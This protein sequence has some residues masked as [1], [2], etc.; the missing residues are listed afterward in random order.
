MG[1]VKSRPQPL[2]LE[3]VISAPE[4]VKKKWVVNDGEYKFDPT[5]NTAADISEPGML[6]EEIIGIA[7][8]ADG[9]SGVFF[10]VVQSGVYVLKAAANAAQE[11]FSHMVA[12]KL[13]IAV[14]RSK[15]LQFGSEGMNTLT[16]TILSATTAP[17]ATGYAIRN[18][19][20]FPVVML[21]E[22]VV[23]NTLPNTPL[24]QVRE[25]SFLK[26]LGSLVALDSLINNS[27]RVPLIWDNPGNAKNIMTTKRAVVGIDQPTVTLAENSPECQKYMKRLEELL[28]KVAEDISQGSSSSMQ[29]VATF[30]GSSINSCLDDA[31]TNHILAGFHTTMTRIAAISTAD[32]QSCKDAVTKMVD[33]EEMPVG[34]AWSSSLGGIDIAFLAAAA[35]VAKNVLST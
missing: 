9:S 8:S 28:C 10:I 12:D 6:A 30:V 19:L 33:V 13:G 14:S 18:L 27:D 26:Q 20:D 4:P 24:E 16:K 3:E 1:C 35:A 7:K 25:P 15:C 17:T 11:Y 2:A 22:Y 23:G 32:L 34:S 5:N 21:L 29:P 31:N